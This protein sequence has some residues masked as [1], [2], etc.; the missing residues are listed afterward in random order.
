MRDL[1]WLLKLCVIVYFFTILLFL[2]FEKKV[3]NS[4]DQNLRGGIKMKKVF[5][6]SAISVILVVVLSSCFL[7]QSYNLTGTWLVTVAYSGQP[8]TN[9]TMT[10]NQNGNAITVYDSYDDFTFTGT[11]NGNNV[12]FS[13]SSSGATISFTGTISDSTHMGGN[14]MIT[15]SSGQ[16]NGTWSAVK[17]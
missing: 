11:V 6:F 8:S 5:L 12:Q 7:L 17:Q 3:Y 15:Y 10:I 2:I 9:L 1:I 14:F 13:Y 4:Y 16:I